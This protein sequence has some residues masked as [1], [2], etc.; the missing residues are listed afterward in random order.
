MAKN[1]IKDQLD[2]IEKPKNSDSD[3]IMAEAKKLQNIDVQKP[4]VIAKDKGIKMQMLAHWASCINIMFK[5]LWFKSRAPRREV[6]TRRGE[7]QPAYKGR[8]MGG[9]IV[10]QHLSSLTSI[11]N[12]S[13]ML[14][15]MVRGFIKPDLLRAY[16]EQSR[17]QLWSLE[18]P[19]D[20][21][22]WH[23]EPTAGTVIMTL[24]DFPHKFGVQFEYRSRGSKDRVARRKFRPGRL[25][26]IDNE[27]VEWR[28]SPVKKPLKFRVYFLVMHFVTEEQ[29]KMKP[30]AAM[31]KHYHGKDLD[32]IP[33]D[34]GEIM[35]G[36]RIELDS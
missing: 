13:D 17:L 21:V 22:G 3:G 31:N 27:R 19:G 16:F 32:I 5:D 12:G 28:I 26:F 8:V 1:R 36:V 15:H 20:F 14:T 29:W 6:P 23:R 9:D 18:E 2:K 10:D 4:P 33:E 7:Y 30:C 35:D 11:Y 25:I 24:Q 34:T